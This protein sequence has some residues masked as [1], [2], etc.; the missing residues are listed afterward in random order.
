MSDQFHPHPDRRRLI[1]AFPA[2][3]FVAACG[4]GRGRGGGT[5][6][7]ADVSRAVTRATEMRA[8]GQRVWCVPFARNASGI[9]IRGD[10]HTWWDQARG[11]YRRGRRPGVGSIICFSDGGKLPLGHIAVV[12]DIVPPPPGKAWLTR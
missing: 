12:S 8:A 6:D 9:Q 11:S 4:G 5:L 3:L 2:L 7:P 10:A 1:A